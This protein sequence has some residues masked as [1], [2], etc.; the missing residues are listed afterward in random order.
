M[1]HPPVA[2]NTSATTVIG[3]A[4]TVTLT[5]TDLETCELAFSV[6][7]APTSGTLGAVGNQACA[8][9]SPNSDTARITYTTG[10]TAG[11]YSFTYKAN[12]GSKD[13][14]VATV[15]I[16]V[17]APPPPVGVSVTGISPNVVS[18]NAGVVSFVITGT[19]FANGASV[20]FLNGSGPAPRVISVARD[21]STQLRASVEIKSGGPRKN[22]LWDV[23]VT[24][25][26][27]STGM[28]VGLLTITP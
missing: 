11:T 20:A 16:T 3:T 1:N 18:Q 28:R 8:A 2:G 10:T 5:A 6:V 22:R 27:G 24:N 12:D 13:S 9:G 7:Q 4:V 15:T 19:G 26:D 21:S 17:T 14:N 25:P 23:Q